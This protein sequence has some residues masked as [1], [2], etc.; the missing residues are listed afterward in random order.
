MLDRKRWV[1]IYKAILIILVVAGHSNTDCYKIIFW[2][3]MPLFFCISGY[4]F[5]EKYDGTI[6]VLRTK[7]KRLLVPWITYFFILDVIP[8]V[9]LE[10]ISVLKFLTRCVMFLWSGK[11]WGGVYWYAPTLFLTI[12]LFSILKKTKVKIQI[13]LLIVF[14]LLAITESIFFI[15]MDNSQI[16]I[17][18]RFPWNFDVCLLSI[19]YFSIGYY[20]KKKKLVLTKTM[21]SILGISSILVVIICIYLMQKNVLVYDMNMKYS[22]YKNFVLP[23]MLPLTFGIIIRISVGLL[24]KIPYINTSLQICGKASM[25]IMYIH[26]PIREYIMAPLFGEK[27]SVICYILLS[28]LLGM[29]IYKLSYRKKWS[30]FILGG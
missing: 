22:Q 28:C 20:L 24:D 19:V 27:Y 11:M 6:S 18:L 3:H 12:L 8:M 29:I 16:P 25:V 1:D 10:K 26:N 2:F 30:L 21:I 14:Y 4:L 9:F 13:F 23:L 17:Y 15:P 7:A 5:N